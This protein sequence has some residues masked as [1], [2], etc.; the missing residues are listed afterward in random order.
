M[1][2][3][4]KILFICFPIS[5]SAYS[6]DC[7]FKNP[8]KKFQP[9]YAKHF[10]I[11]YFDTYKVIH[12]DNEQY[13]LS[14]KKMNC[15]TSETFITT[16]VKNVAMMS[17]TYLPALV[18]LHQEK[19]L[20][21]FQGK[22]YIVS[23]KFKHHEIKEI[24]YKLNPENLLALK[25]DLVMGYEANLYSNE[26]KN[27]FK[28][29][30]IPLVLN[31]DFQEESPLA[32][33]E[34][35]IF[36]SSFYNL[37]ERAQFLF[38]KI[39]DDYNEIKIEN[40]NFKKTKV[41]VG[42]IQEGFWITCGGKSD[43]AKLIEDAGGELVLGSRSSQTQKISL[44][45]LFSK[46]INADIWLTHNSWKSSLEFKKAVGGDRRYL[47][48]QAKKIV[49][50]NRLMNKNYFSDYWETALARPDLLLK[51]LSYLFHSSSMN[52]KEL[53]WYRKL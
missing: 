52:D 14:S 3:S 51:E 19:S 4:L 30:H 13:I 46:K 29:L 33:A 7:N 1:R 32:R 24:S 10:T 53:L 21:S 11:D 20:T 31:K 25:A 17:T 5:F 18:L 35:L 15:T 38:N 48:I 39:A 8:I 50:N 12:V 36:I 37:E 16:P 45:T 43:L 27:V 9:K 2:I 41:L 44:E 47:K 22:N 42:D 23:S 26:Q 28:K 6:I 49:N 40:Q 34:W